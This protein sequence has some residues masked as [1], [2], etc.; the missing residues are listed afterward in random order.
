MATATYMGKI[1]WVP[2]I[3]DPTFIGWLTVAVYFLVAVTCLKAALIPIDNNLH[4][5]KKI[6]LFWLFLTFS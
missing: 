4:Q 5:E 3:G 6:K 2:E 1:I